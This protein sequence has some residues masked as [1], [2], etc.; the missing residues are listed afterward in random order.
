MSSWYHEA[1]LIPEALWTRYALS[2]CGLI[3]ATE[4]IT[5]VSFSVCIACYPG[6]AEV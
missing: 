2:D 1:S 3:P 6:A 4:L 5:K